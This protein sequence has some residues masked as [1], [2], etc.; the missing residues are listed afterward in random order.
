MVLFTYKDAS[1]LTIAK[2][3]GRPSLIGNPFQGHQWPDMKNPLPDNQ[4]ESWP[5]SA[6]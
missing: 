4:G 1:W 5:R 6:L 2:V 3:R